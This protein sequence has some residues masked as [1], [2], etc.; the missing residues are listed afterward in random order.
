MQADKQGFCPHTRVHSGVEASL[1]EFGWG[2]SLALSGDL[3]QLSL[4]WWPPTTFCI[5]PTHRSP[6]SPTSSPLVLVDPFRMLLYPKCLF[7]ELFWR[8]SSNLS[9][10]HQEAKIGGTFYFFHFSAQ[11][12]CH[13][14][15]SG[16]ININATQTDSHYTATPC[17]GGWLGWWV[18][19]ISWPRCRVINFVQSSLQLLKLLIDSSLSA[20]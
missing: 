18:G 7:Q 19:N 13:N 10:R 6:S 2:Q 8:I 15:H 4:C 5:N 11:R 3:N 12:H 9:S 20:A 16:L 1:A 14:D 17:M